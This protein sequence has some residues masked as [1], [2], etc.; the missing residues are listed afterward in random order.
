MDSK[1]LSSLPDIGVY[2]PE[3]RRLLA[4]GAQG[5]QSHMFSAYATHNLLLALFAER[6]RTRL[7]ATSAC[8]SWL[9]TYDAKCS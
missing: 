4:A 2:L 6:K 3:I 7:I 8:R 5:A 9:E 1:R